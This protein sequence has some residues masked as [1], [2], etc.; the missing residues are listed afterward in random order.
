MAYV[1]GILYDFLSAQEYGFRTAFLCKSFKRAVVYTFQICFIAYSAFV[2]RIE[3]NDISIESYCQLSLVLK[4]VYLGRSR[5]VQVYQSARRKFSFTYAVSPQDVQAVLQAW[6]SVRD[7]C[8]GFSFAVAQMLLLCIVESA[9][10][11]TDCVE[12]FAINS[13]PQ[14]VT[15]FF[16]TQGRGANVFCTFVARLGQ[17]GFIQ[18]QIVCTGFSEDSLSA[19]VSGLEFFQSFL[20]GNVYDVER[21]VCQFSQVDSTSCCFGFYYRRT[22]DCVI[23][24]RCFCLLRSADSSEHRSYRH[25]LHGP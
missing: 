16:G 12:P 11:G 9:M 18:Y 15:V 1:L 13:F 24:R 22:A 7:I 10:V 21:S 5:C 25:F 4:T 19:A 17:I 20:A 6:C 3:D 14:S 8:K 2:C 23:I